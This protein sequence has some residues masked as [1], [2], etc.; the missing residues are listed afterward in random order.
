V[1]GDNLDEAI[2]RVLANGGQA[3]MPKDNIPGIGWLAYVQEPG[4]TAL[5]MLQA[6]PNSR[7]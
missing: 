7:M 5:G 4:G 1:D 2:K 6:D 3:I